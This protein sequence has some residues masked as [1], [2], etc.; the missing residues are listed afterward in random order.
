MSHFTVLV[1]IG[2]RTR[3]PIE[4]IVAR[5]LYPFWELDLVGEEL[6]NDPRAK[7]VPRYTG[8][9]QEIAK[10][11]IDGLQTRIDDM[12]VQEDLYHKEKR[13][14]HTQGL[15]DKYTER[16]GASDYEGI[17]TSWTGNLDVNPENL[18][19][20]GTFKNPIAKWDWYEIGGHWSG[21]I[22]S[23]DGE[24]DICLV[25]DLERC[26]EGKIRIR[27]FAVLH[28]G[29]WMTKGNMGWFGMSDERPEDAEAWDDGYNAVIDD[30]NPDDVVV[31]VDCHI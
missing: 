3:E 19:E 7:F 2:K 8:T 6:A 24:K 25:K 9:A 26:G 20:R 28:N 5:V 12:T 11:I 29:N 21:M 4:A 17:I 16:Y 22:E 18:L 14:S 30:M 10:K 31:L 1:N 23:P 27:T 15:L 13:I